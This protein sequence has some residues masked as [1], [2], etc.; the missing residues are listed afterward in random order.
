MVNGIRA[1]DPRWLNK[2]RGS[3]FYVGSRVQQKT[4]EESRGTYRPKCL[5]YKNKDEENTEW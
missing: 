4:P 2:E 1:S 5:R 3:K